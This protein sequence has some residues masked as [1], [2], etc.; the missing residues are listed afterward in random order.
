MKEAD[1]KL[2]VQQ[3]LE[4]AGYF[5]LRI[6]SGKVRVKRGYMQLCP[7]G[8]AD[9][10]VFHD[11][12]TCWIE[13]KAD[14][15]KQKPSQMIFEAKAKAAGHSYIIARSLDEVRDFLGVRTI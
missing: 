1:V 13:M 9:L 12:K 11:G 8:T 3:W 10:V 6:Q 5:W 7:E 2:A 14:K 15:G 4:R